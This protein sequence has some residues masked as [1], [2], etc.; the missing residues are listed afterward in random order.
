MPTKHIDDMSWRGIEMLTVDANKVSALLRPVKEADV[1]RLVLQKGLG[2]VSEEDLRRLSERRAE[3]GILL[4]RQGSACLIVDNATPEDVAS[5]LVQDAPLLAVVYGKSVE[6]RER[7]RMTVIHQLTELGHAIPSL[8][9]GDSANSVALL[10]EVVENVQAGHRYVVA[11]PAQDAWGA[12]SHLSDC[13]LIPVTGYEPGDDTPVDDVMNL[14]CL[15]TVVTGQGRIV[16][17]SESALERK[18]REVMRSIE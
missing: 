7:L 15:G 1:L 2:A 14:I 8:L 13:L 10:Q 6:I 4:W 18:R 9:I 16:F 12:L 5:L 3:Q 11:L 17:P